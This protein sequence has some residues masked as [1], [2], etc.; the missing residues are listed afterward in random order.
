[1]EWISSDNCLKS[2][3]GLLKSYLFDYPYAAL[4]FSATFAGFHSKKRE[5]A[6]EEMKKTVGADKFTSKTE[7]EYK[8]KMAEM[9]KVSDTVREIEFKRNA[10]H[11]GYTST[12]EVLAGAFLE[13]K[14]A[15]ETAK[16]KIKDEVD[17]LL[18]KVSAISDIKGVQDLLN[19]N[20]DAKLYGDKTILT[21]ADVKSIQDRIDLKAREAIDNHVEKAL[22]GTEGK[23]DNTIL[24]TLKKSM[25]EYINS[26]VASM[27]TEQVRAQVREALNKVIMK[28]KKGGKQENKIIHNRAVAFAKI[29]RF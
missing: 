3:V 14:E 23:K 19:K 6:R 17:K 4:H 2:K 9:L 5:D 21:E 11:E 22:S 20:T 29:N 13:A 27:K 18:G 15:I 16:K 7:N 25:E 8:A 28:T 10:I 24:G 26:G 1:M 12:K